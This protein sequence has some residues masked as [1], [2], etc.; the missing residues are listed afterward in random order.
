M[1]KS[2]KSFMW[3][4]AF[5]GLLCASAP[6]FADSLPVG[7]TVSNPSTL[8]PSGAFVAVASTGVQNFSMVDFSHQVTG[9]GTVI[10]EVGHFGSSTTLSF[11]YQFTS[12]TGDVVNRLTGTNYGTFSTDVFQ[13]STVSGFSNLGTGT[14]A[15]ILANRA[16]A[17]PVGFTM[18]TASVPVTSY[19]LIV[20]TDA[21]D[22]TAGN[23]ALQDGGNT[24]VAGFA[25]TRAV[26]EFGSASLMGL[27]LLGVGGIFGVRR[28]RM[29]AMA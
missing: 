5:A 1:R 11:L 22:Y 27:L 12:S 24:N 18:G 16:S 29:P 7:G 13:A 26:P 23:I 17:D 8:P 4:L 2:L 21:T 25:P 9:T 15:A 3:L 14:L 28:F 20:N 10:E 6:G 19:V